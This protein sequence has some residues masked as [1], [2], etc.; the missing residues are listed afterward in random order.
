MDNQSTFKTSKDIIN[1]LAA[2]Y[3]NCFST[4]GE[5]K[6]LK[7]GIFHDLV[8][9]LDE[10]SGISKV[11]LRAALRTYTLSWRYLHGI[12]KGAHRVDLDGNLSEILTVEHVQ[13]AQKQLKEGKEKLNAKRREERKESARTKAVV[14]D[15]PVQEISEPHKK[16]TKRKS[17]PSKRSRLA[18]HPADIATLNV[19]DEVKVNL[20]S[21]P[22]K[23]ILIAIEKENVRVKVQSGMELTVRSEYIIE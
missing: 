14:S 1:Y 10:N 13:Y 20:S 19:G 8:K 18:A 12:K 7:I 4:E 22:V 2:T 21:K 11:R 6:P 23:A 9:R 16:M 17:T 5:A 15:K 3:P